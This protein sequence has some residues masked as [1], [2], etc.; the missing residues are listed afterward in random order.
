MAA[1]FDEQLTT[2]VQQI[3]FCIKFEQLYKREHL[4]FNMYVSCHNL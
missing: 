4:V 1:E 2:S 3:E